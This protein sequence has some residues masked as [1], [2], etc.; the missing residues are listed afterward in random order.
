M[1][2]GDTFGTGLRNDSSIASLTNS[3]TISGSTEAKGIYDYFGSLDTLTNNGTIQGGTGISL[4]GGSLGTLTN[5][6]TITGETYSAVN[7]TGEIDSIV[8]NSGDSMDGA[9]YGI[10]NTTSSNT[11]TGSSSACTINSIDNS[12]AISSEFGGIYNS[13]TIKEIT[14]SGDIFNVDPDADFAGIENFGTIS[15]STTGIRNT[16]SISGLINTGTISGTGNAIYS[17]SGD[18]GS[19]TNIGVIDGDIAVSNQNLT[20]VGGT[21]NF[22]TLTGG[23]ITLDSG[24][25]LTFGAGEQVLNDTVEGGGGLGVAPVDVYVAPNGTLDIGSLGYITGDVTVE[26]SGTVL[27]TGTIA[28][29]ATIDGTYEVDIPSGYKTGDNAGLTVDGTV[30]I[31]AGATLNVNSATGSAVGLSSPATLLIADDGI[32]GTFTNITGNVG[33]GT[34]LQ[35][36]ELDGSLYLEDL[37]ESS[38]AGSA[39]AAYARAGNGLAAAGVLDQLL[40]RFAADPST[41]NSAQTALI[42]AAT[43]VSATAVP[44]L[45]A[46]LSGQIHAD[47]VAA[48]PQAGW[49]LENSVYGHLGDEAGAPGTGSR[50]WSDVSTEAGQRGSDNVASGFNSNVSQVVARADLLARGK[51]VLGIGYAYTTD[52]VTETADN[53]NMTENGGFLYGQFPVG[54]FMVSGIGS[55]GESSTDTQRVNP[56]GGGLLKDDHVGGDNAMVSMNVMPADRAPQCH[57]RPVRPRDLAACVAGRDL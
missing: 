23:I 57:A 31:G 27:G 43:G 28:G 44:Q 41:L 47:M 3:G 14:N 8:N 46:G 34:K 11:G 32:D 50:M 22:G 12:S 2:S 30:T 5:S 48:Q 16:G 56:L 51:A 10:V 20:I 42:D 36:V 19:V 9:D 17:N 25:T 29:N 15:G 40:K 37:P 55:Y 52:N 13:G 4:I 7:N 49:Q 21:D 54:R 53:G 6:G 38:G 1:I 45:L 26:L 35:I 33:V 39:F 18:L 24:D